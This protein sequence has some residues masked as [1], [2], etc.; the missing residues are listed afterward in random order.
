MTTSWSEPAVEAT[1]V[2]REVAFAKSEL[3]EGGWT[4]LA[5]G[6][7][8]GDRVTEHAL[9]GLA[10]QAESAA[11]AKG[12]ATG[13]AEG[14]R[15]AEARAT[16]EREE[17]AAR[18]AAEEQRREEEHRAAV[19]TFVR[20]TAQLEEALAAATERVESHAT[21]VALQLTEALL[22]H[23]LAVAEAPGVD[24][25]RRALALMP[26]EPVVR[27]RVAPAES[28]HPELAQLAGAAVVVPDP[29]LQRGD[30]LVETDTRVVDVRASHALARVREVL[31]R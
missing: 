24:A 19:A 27:I 18:H 1:P 25:V 29:T 4:R 2:V 20:A 16:T 28:T 6:S 23:E 5:G 15:A 3:R 31:A 13:W 9:S 14:R 10:A 8:L 26:G 7:V 12:Y 17:V 21:A 22:G 30:A 11:R